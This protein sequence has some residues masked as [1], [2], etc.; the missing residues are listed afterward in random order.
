MAEGKCAY[1]SHEKV[2]LDVRQ[3]PQMGGLAPIGAEV[4]RKAEMEGDLSKDGDGAD[5]TKQY[6]HRQIKVWQQAH[7]YSRRK[8]EA[9]G[10]DTGRRSGPIRLRL[11]VSAS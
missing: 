7:I 5:P 10:Q 11:Q 9:G 8:A 1:V 6:L 2:G 3:I 4:P